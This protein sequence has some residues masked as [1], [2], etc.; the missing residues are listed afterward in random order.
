MIQSASEV[1][2][3]LVDSNLSWK[4][5]EIVGGN[6]LSFIKRV[7]EA[8]LSREKAVRDEGLEEAAKKLEE[9]D[10]LETKSMGWEYGDM[11]D[12]AIDIHDRYIRAIRALKGKS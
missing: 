12:V 3:E 1:A 4:G 8:L 9:L 5:N 11:E 2:K 6:R 7:S 10:P